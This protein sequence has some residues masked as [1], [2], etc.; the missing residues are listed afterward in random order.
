MDDAGFSGF[1]LNIAVVGLGLIGGSYAKALR[2]LNPQSICGIDRDPAVVREALEAGIIDRGGTA[3]ADML[4]DAD[5]VILA[6]YPR[7]MLEFLKENSG[8]FKDGAVIT[9]TCG[10]KRGIIDQVGEFLPEN[11]DFVGGHPM[12]GKEKKGLKAAD[13]D[14]FKGAN[15]IVTPVETNRKENVELVERMAV[16]IGCRNVVSISPE[17]HDRVVSLTSHLPHAIAVSLMNSCT[18]SNDLGLFTGG[19]FKDATRV[20]SINSTLWSQLFTL[21]SE[22]LLEEIE[23]FEESMGRIKQALV[24]EDKEAL[25]DLFASASRNKKNMA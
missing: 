15:Y 21:N 9:D 11:V 8:F 5:L 18:W 24:S 12:A 20:A 1:N 4:G 2:D 22:N 25:N 19:S 7:E 6:L 16:A 23:R 17:E 10:I 3:A 14:L 13:K